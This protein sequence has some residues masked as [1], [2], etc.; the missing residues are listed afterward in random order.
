[1]L[2]SLADLELTTSQTLDSTPCEIVNLRP[3]RDL[4]I[5]WVVLLEVHVLGSCQMLPHEVQS[6]PSCKPTA[7][8]Q[9]LRRPAVGQILGL[10][11]SQGPLAGAGAQTLGSVIFCRFCLMDAMHS[12]SHSWP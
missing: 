11:L 6:L 7:R 2:I 3:A 12:R 5:G 4:G 8:V 10:I 9:V 1:M